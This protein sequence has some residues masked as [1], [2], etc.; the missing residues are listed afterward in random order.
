MINSLNARFILT[1][2][3]ICFPTFSI[4]G[5]KVKW[6]KLD[7]T[8]GIGGNEIKWELLE[9]REEEDFSDIYLFDDLSKPP[10]QQEDV[11]DL[12][13]SIKLK[14]SDFFSPQRIGTIF[15]INSFLPAY[16]TSH[17]VYALSTFNS[18]GAAGGSG[19][20][21]YAYMLDI[22]LNENN[23]LSLFY[24]VADD[25]LYSYI[26][27]DKLVPNYW[28]SYGFAFKKRLLNRDD[29][30]LATFA[31]L[32]SM[33]IRNGNSSYGNIFD[34]TGLSFSD[35]NLVGSFSLP[36]SRKLS[37]NLGLHFL[38]GGSFFP[39]TLGEVNNKDNFYGNNL[40]LGSGLTWKLNQNVNSFG[41]I[42]MPLGPGKNT[43]D[44]S[45]SFHRI[46]IY[47]LGIN[48]D[49]NPIIGFEGRITNG[50]GATPATSI[51]TIPSSNEVLYFAGL[52]YKPFALDSPQKRLSKRHTL[53]SLGG[54]SV[55]SA[56]IP[57]R[58]KNNY[59]LNI[60][61]KGNLFGAFSRSLSNSFQL[62]LINFGSF[63][64]QNAGRSNENPF[65]RTY[66]NDS[67]FST[68]Y[69]GKFVLMSP[70]REGFTWLSTRISVGRNQQNKQGYLFNEWIN[71]FEIN[72][73]LAV[74]I[75]PKMAISG[76][77]SLYSLGIGSNIHLSD[78]Y[79]LITET[80]IS[81]SKYS[82][83][84]LSLSLR[85]VFSEDLYF[86]LYLSSALG[87]HDAGQLLSNNEI[88]KGFRV[89]FLY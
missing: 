62:D 18:G 56:L 66:M 24:S 77:V 52:T 58:A 10:S 6:E 75:N 12:V 55:G 26:D 88:R 15:P 74:N 57:P 4:A 36:I 21:N 85:K 41:S 25:P 83:S 9:N 37:D 23:Q 42:V 32:E 60:D 35:R 51:L 59:S 16:E 5:T 13:N 28:E 53:L 14:S 7:T 27:G 82:E 2:L 47:N 54:L 39:S 17:S 33:T 89:N 81:L 80:N 3:L 31:S 71:T 19:N 22:G 44:S 1:I 78:V 84:N 48:F 64:N 79:Q 8:I 11:N 40:Y 20:Q 30:S 68:R 61:N 43:F 69:G 87:L 45:N 63:K 76:V 86:D 72:E 50:F 29:W 46:P 70:L 67:N 34:E 65:I 38:V 49:L 73:N